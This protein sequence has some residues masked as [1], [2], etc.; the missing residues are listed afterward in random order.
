MPAEVIAQDT[1]DSI[2]DHGPGINLARN[3]KTYPR[4]AVVNQIVHREDRGG[5]AMAAL[6]DGVE[7]RTRAHPRTA[8]VA[9][10]AFRH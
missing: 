1:F 7:L 3:R 10:V 6:E 5:G 8:R 2:A 4:S 9:G